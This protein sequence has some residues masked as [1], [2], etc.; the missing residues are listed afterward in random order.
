MLVTPREAE[1]SLALLRRIDGAL[2]A[3]VKDRAGGE[4][5]VECFRALLKSLLNFKGPFGIPIKFQGPY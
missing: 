5:P 3:T 4:T 1:R 2:S